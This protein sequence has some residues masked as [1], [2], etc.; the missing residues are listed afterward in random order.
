MSD[1]TPDT[2][3][4]GKASRRQNMKFVYTIILSLVIGLGY[5]LRGPIAGIF[6]GSKKSEA[7]ATAGQATPKKE[8]KILYWYDPMLADFKSGKPGKSPMGMDLIPKYE[9]D[10]GGEG[11]VKIDPAVVQTIG[12]RTADV[13]RMDIAKIIRAA[14]VVTY[15]ETRL[16]KIQ[17]KVSGWI[18][19]LYFNTTGQWVSRD[20][21]LLELYSPDLV[22]AQEEF[23]LALKYR[24][25]LKEGGAD[26]TVAEGG[27]Q[28]YESAL[29]RLQLL[30]VPAHQIAEL[31]ADRK[32]KKTLHIHSPVS[33]VITK[34]EVI[35]GMFVE[36]N[37]ILYEIA[38]LSTVW[39]NA[40]IFEYEMSY[41]KVGQKAVLSLTAFP[42]RE[43]TGKISY[44][45]PFLDP[46]TRSVK[47]RVE[48]SNPKGEIKPDMYGSVMI[49]AGVARDALAVP[50]EAVLKTG[51]R[52]MVFLDK[53]EGKF[54]PREV[55][56]G[57]AGDGMTQ[58]ISGLAEG[59][60][61][62]VSAQFLIDSESKLR[63][64]AG[65]MG[66]NAA[67]GHAGHEGMT[68]PAPV[69]D[70]K[71][72]EAVSRPAA[73]PQKAQSAP[74]K[75]GSAATGEAQPEKERKI[76]YWY[77]PMLADFKSDKP[78]KS[79]M[80]MEMIP[81]YEDEDDAGKKDH[82]GHEGM[83]HSKPEGTDHTNHEGMDHS[84]HEG[85]DHSKNSDSPK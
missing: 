35:Q 5:F 38:D 58:I 36:P 34:K 76:L 17:G 72:H 75:H 8:R 42:G 53:G 70:H 68:Q 85:M 56:A 14:G 22:T 82:S 27:E 6:T 26:K 3:G 83:D 2:E 45:F 59:E 67:P 50:A 73:E 47:A 55:R 60:K 40:D 54:E 20:G 12:V 39:V 84:T 28:L 79:P 30:D 24:N 49:D 1:N 33:G 64:A 41:V 51:V 80:G 48:F 25:T 71:A 61:V 43:F 32:V 19:K 44:V 74:H 52:D 63:E 46:K 62:V 29:R 13:K 77:D 18:E 16:A 4:A 10:G 66:G 78:G 57:M 7:P 65:K 21:I 11:I 81:K 23:L 37:T 9:D 69:P 15:D 31:S